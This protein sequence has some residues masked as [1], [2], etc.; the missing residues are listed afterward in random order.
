MGDAEARGIVSL[1]ISLDR[2]SNQV[3]DGFRAIELT[4]PGDELVELRRQV[5]IQGDG[6][7]FHASSSNA[8]YQ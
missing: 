3:P 5:V 1:P 7:P 8:G 6:E 4:A 2:T